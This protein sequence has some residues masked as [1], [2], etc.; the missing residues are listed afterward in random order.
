MIRKDSAVKID[1]DLLKKIEDFIKKNKFY[2]TSKKQVVN[3]AII[4]FLNSRS[5][6]KS[7]NRGK[8][9]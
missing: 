5:L 9:R 8:K 7:R 6:D 2:Y 1:S 3:L 4:E